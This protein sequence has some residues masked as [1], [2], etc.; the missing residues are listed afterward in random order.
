MNFLWHDW[1]GLI[2]VA[3]VLL[4]FFLLQAHKLRGQGLVYQSM[5]LLGAAGVILS[6]V[7]GVFNLAAFLQELAWLL[8]SL[9]GITRGVKSRRE[10][11]VPRAL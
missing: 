1:A 3:L 8:I 4:A 6:L 10:A 9:Y 7:F 2:G 11:D 5:N